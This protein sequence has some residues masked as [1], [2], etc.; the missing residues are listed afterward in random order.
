MI[1]T[2]SFGLRVASSPTFWID[3]A[4]TWPWTWAMSI[5]LAAWLGTTWISGAGGNAAAMRLGW[6]AASAGA[7]PAASKRL[8]FRRDDAADQRPDHEQHDDEGEQRHHQRARR[9]RMMSSLVN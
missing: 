3:W 5:I 4:C 7:A 8:D 1:E 9:A 6:P 2:V